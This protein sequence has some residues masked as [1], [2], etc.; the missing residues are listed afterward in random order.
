MTDHDTPPPGMQG[1]EALIAELSVGIN[2]LQLAV[3]DASM[4][5]A[6]WLALAVA[7]RAQVW[8]SRAIDIDDTTDERRFRS[9]DGLLVDSTGNVIEVAETQFPL[10]VRAFTAGRTRG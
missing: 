3:N 8:A 2:E 9:M 10:L 1:P 5:R 4:A 7:E 6:T